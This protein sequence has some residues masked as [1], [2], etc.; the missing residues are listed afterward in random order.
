MRVEKS[1]KE[2][3]NC[4]RFASF[5]TFAFVFVQYGKAPYVYRIHYQ[6]RRF[7]GIGSPLSLTLSSIYTYNMW[8]AWKA[9]KR[10]ACTAGGQLYWLCSRLTAT[11]TYVTEASRY[12]WFKH[13]AD[14]ERTR[15]NLSF[16]FS[17]SFS[18][19][20][21]LSCRA[22]VGGPVPLKLPVFLSLQNSGQAVRE[23]STQQLRIST[24]DSIVVIITVA[25]IISILTTTVDV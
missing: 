13:E 12:R 21:F 18:F 1:R 24:H 22:F 20:L 19:C 7:M 10:R 6:N 9:V 8:K 17:F 2:K 25:S 16:S 11:V 23:E 14:W 3:S 5:R 15:L 4:D